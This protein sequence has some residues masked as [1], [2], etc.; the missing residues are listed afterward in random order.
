MRPLF[1]F[2]VLVALAAAQDPC[3]GN[4]RGS[5][6]IRTT[7]A[8]I[9][10][11][12]RVDFGSPTAPNSLAVLSHS[13]GL[14]PSVFPH[15][16]VGT[17][18]LDV[19]SPAY[20]ADTFFL[21]GSGAAQVNVAIPATPSLLSFAPI[22]AHAVALEGLGGGNLALS[23]SRTAAISWEL[24]DTHRTVGPLQT[25]RAFHTATNLADSPLSNTQGVL[26]AGGGGGNF[27]QP[28][29]SD[30]T[31]IYDLTR[32]VFLPGPTM[33]QRRAGHTATLLVDGRVLIAG[34]ADTGGA[35]TA[36]AEVYDPATRSF[37]AVAPMG[38]PRSTHRASR[39]ADGRVL[40]TGG[41]SDWTAAHLNFVARLNTAQDTAELFDPATD[42]WTHVAGVMAAPRAGHSQVVLP[43]GEVLVISGIRGGVANATVFGTAL[44]PVYTA[45][46]ERFD[47]TTD[48]FVADAPVAFG[49]AFA[50]ASLDGSG[51][52]LTGGL[53]A[54]SGNLGAAVPTALC[55]G[56]DGTSWASRP[57]IPGGLFGGATA[58]HTQ[59][60]LP[61]GR[62]LVHGGISDLTQLGATVGCA[63]YDAGSWGVVSDLG[64]HGPLGQVASPRGTHTATLLPDGAIL[65]AGG[66]H[67]VTAYADGF[68][69]YP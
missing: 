31:D 40:V 18:C 58:F 15:P 47:P 59:V 50:G 36:T 48:Q 45:T 7:P 22:Y 34:G 38:T 69:Y 27:M 14:G 5:A 63:R 25:A 11:A 1:V 8:M 20:S 53:I 60:T 67:F 23:I 24:P 52:L 39:L 26:I 66:S 29:G 19:Q 57:V 17:I 56:W 65:L 32:R 28:V 10:G 41:F 54:D 12:L 13:T 44:V 9:G 6:Y 46:C 33:T 30:T 16:L 35:V 2:A 51:V 21:D 3:R 64:S 37:R 62:I 61:S 4:G 49:R 68:V 55:E 42:S 43:S